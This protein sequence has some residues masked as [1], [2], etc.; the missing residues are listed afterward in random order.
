MK[1]KRGDLLVFTSNPDPKKNLRLVKDD[2]N[3]DIVDVY[4]LN[5]KTSNY[6]QVGGT[7]MYK[8]VTS[9]FRGEI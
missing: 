6:S 3:N 5:S 7:Y 8:L 9:I 2:E 1:F 4:Y